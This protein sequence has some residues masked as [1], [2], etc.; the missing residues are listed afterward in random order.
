M[1]VFGEKSGK[2]TILPAGTMNVFTKFC[3]GSSG[4]VTWPPDSAG[5]I[6]WGP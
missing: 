3:G 5:L 2:L 1:V 4:K 6:L